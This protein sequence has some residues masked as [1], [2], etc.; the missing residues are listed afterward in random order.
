MTFTSTFSRSLLPAPCQPVASCNNGRHP[1][2]DDLAV[3]STL[4]SWEALKAVIEDH[5]ITKKTAF[6]CR[7]N[8]QTRVNYV[9]RQ[10][11]EGC[12]FRVYASLN[13][14]GDIEIKKFCTEHLC[15]GAP[16]S[17]RTTANTQSWLQRIV[18]DLLY[19]STRAIP[20]I[21]ACVWAVVTRH[22][23]PLMLRLPHDRCLH[24]AVFIIESSLVPNKAFY[25]SKL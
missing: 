23:E 10:K 24:Q 17:T 1:K 13:S 14:E 8:D 7:P 4:P 25:R 19:V 16:E 12:P 5:S 22:S 2:L 9:C 6:F 20:W 3:G 18:P 11:D 21:V 15:A